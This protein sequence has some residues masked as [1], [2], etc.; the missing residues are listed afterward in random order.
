MGYNNNRQNYH[1][2]DLNLY[3][4]KTPAA[5]MHTFLPYFPGDFP[6]NYPGKPEMWS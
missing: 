6:G 2:Q 5:G 3:T 1:F 4:E